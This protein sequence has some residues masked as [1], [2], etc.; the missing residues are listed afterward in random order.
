MIERTE[1]KPETKNTWGD[2]LFFVFDTVE[3]A[4]SFAL[5][6]RDLVMGRNWAEKG[7]DEETSIR[8]ALHAGPVLRCEDPILKATNYTGYHVNMAARL[9]PITPPGQVYATEQFAA[10]ASF[11]GAVGFAC[12]YAGQMPFPKGFGA[13]PI[14][15]V[16]RGI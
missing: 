6:L 16:R 2:G 13:Y 9:E 4:G 15:H 7:L 12:D 11:R 1:H 10:L 8:I 14:F 3:E 5:E